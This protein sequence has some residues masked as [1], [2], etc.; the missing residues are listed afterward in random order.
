MNGVTLEQLMIIDIET[1]P[2]Y[3][4]FHGMSDTFQELWR[5][6]HVSLKI[7]DDTPEQSYENRAGIYAEFGKI[8]CISAG[9]FSKSLE[10]GL[11]FRLKSFHGHNEK[12][13]L[14]Q[15][16]ESVNKKKD[17]VF[18]GHNIKEFDIPYLCRRM[19]IQR[20]PLPAALDFS[21]R[22]P[23]EVPSLDTLHLWRFG[24]YKSYT[25]LKLLA[26]V[27]NI[28][29]P[30]EDIDGKD[31]ARVYWHENDLQRIVRYCQRDVVTVARLMLL[32]MKESLPLND[33][34]VEIVG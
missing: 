23:W 1:V 22:K 33:T 18:A 31:V 15:F 11:R 3:K 16:C 29:S 20:V 8:I 12:E 17:V 13:L 25:S 34:D 4:N 32:F 14:E 7:E 27:M 24:D 26:A 2:Q 6:K 19:M 5:N 30:K 21:G 9:Y 28:P 10:H